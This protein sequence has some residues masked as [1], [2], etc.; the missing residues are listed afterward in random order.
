MSLEALIKLR[1]HLANFNA[2][3]ALMIQDYWPQT[4]M[5]IQLVFVL[6]NIRDR[7]ENESNPKLNRVLK[8]IKI[9]FV[10]YLNKKINE[11]STTEQDDL[12]FEIH[13]IAT[14]QLNEARSVVIEDI[15]IS[16]LPP[17]VKGNLIKAF[18]NNNYQ[19]VLRIISQFH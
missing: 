6:M 7:L 13:E 16:T 17:Q 10:D 12:I 4:T 9:D 18:Q 5:K 19:D 14:F 15:E 11:R 3:I 2:D 8:Q 1:A